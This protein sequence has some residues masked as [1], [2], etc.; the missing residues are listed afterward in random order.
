MTLTLYSVHVLS[1]WRGGPLVLDPPWL[2]Y[3]V[4]VTV[5]VIVALFWRR[6]V[7]RGPLELL[8]ARLESGSRTA[9]AR[10]LRTKEPH[11]RTT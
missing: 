9:A 1:L 11:S 8:A 5:G 3:A 7:G 2:L 6:H 10:V 4:Q